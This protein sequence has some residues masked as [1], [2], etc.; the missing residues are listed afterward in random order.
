MNLH[1]LDMKVMQLEDGVNCVW[2]DKE[3]FRDK[4][5]QYLNDRENP[6]WMKIR[7]QGLKLAQKYTFSKRLR[8][9]EHL[10]K[11]KLRAI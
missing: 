6:K 9:M 11:K 5:L 8:H 1:P 10:I 4:A 7:R 3:N 2:I